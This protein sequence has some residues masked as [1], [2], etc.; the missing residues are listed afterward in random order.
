MQTS[1]EV[2][3]KLVIV[4]G[5]LIC[6]CIEEA[7]KIPYILG[8]EQVLDILVENPN[9]FA[10]LVRDEHQDHREYATDRITAEI[11]AIAELGQFE[12]LNAYDLSFEG[13]LES[14]ADL[15]PVLNLINGLTRTFMVYTGNALTIFE[16][17]FQL[18][19]EKLRQ[20]LSLTGTSLRAMELT[21][22]D[23]AG[24]EKRAEEYL[25]AGQFL[26]AFS[27]V[28]LLHAKII[29]RELVRFP[30][31][32][33][34]LDQALVEIGLA[35]ANLRAPLITFILRGC[36]VSQGNWQ[37]LFDTLVDVIEK[38]PDGRGRATIADHIEGDGIFC[39]N[40]IGESLSSLRRLSSEERKRAIESKL[41]EFRG[42]AAQSPNSGQQHPQ[43]G[44]A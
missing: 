34:V 8:Q 15:E 14:A 5:N 20:S 4:I 33:R 35:D 39:C 12:A 1:P 2:R 32:G 28:R 26:Q 37:D 25:V 3:H 40:F 30:P 9:I 18:L 10:E 36:Y 17:E 22:T 6:R 24:L 21:P 7:R 38:E 11:D 31:S 13:R 44:D 29:T 16:K 27:F 23:M 19:I 43:S 42:Q 41:A